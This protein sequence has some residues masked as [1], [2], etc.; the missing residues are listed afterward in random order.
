MD[1]KSLSFTSEKL[2]NLTP[3]LE[4]CGNHTPLHKRKKKHMYTAPGKLMLKKLSKT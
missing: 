1:F 2:Q 3:A 4:K